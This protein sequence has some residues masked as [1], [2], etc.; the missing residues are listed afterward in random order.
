MQAVFVSPRPRVTNGTPSTS[1]LEIRISLNMLE[2]LFNLKQ[3][4]A[5]KQ[6]GISLT[7]L[8][9][10]CRKLGILRWPRRAA[11]EWEAA[12]GNGEAEEIIDRGNLSGSG[13]GWRR[14]EEGSDESENGGVLDEG[15][16][17]DARTE[18]I[19]ESGEE[20][21]ASRGLSESRDLTG[22]RPE[23]IAEYM[24]NSL[25]EEE[26]DKMYSNFLI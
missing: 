5:A 18:K 2:P 23:W 8:K 26:G 21:S 10:A 11:A 19:D 15:R 16:D 12:D 9:S 6:L 24:R 13:E 22:L 1:H 3:E 14:E 25:D 20:G 4:D 17:D 7:S